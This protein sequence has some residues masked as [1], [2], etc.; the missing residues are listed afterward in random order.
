MSARGSSAG[1]DSAPPVNQPSLLRVVYAVMFFH[2]TIPRYCTVYATGPSL[3]G[4]P[5]TVVTGGLIY[6]KIVHK[7]QVNTKKHK[8]A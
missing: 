1:V 3:L 4:R 8:D 2:P 5:C 7:V 6:Y